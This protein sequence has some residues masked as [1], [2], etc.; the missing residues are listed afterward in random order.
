MNTLIEQFYQSFKD[1]N[2]EGMTACYADDVEFED[3][4]FGKLKGERAKNMWR[5][6]I[7]SQQGK[8]F[9]VT[10]SDVTENSAHWEAKYTFSQSGRKVHNIIKAT[11]VIENGKIIKHTDDFNLHKWAKQALG[12]KGFLLG[13]TSFFKKKLQ[14]QTNRLLDKYEANKSKN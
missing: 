4:A 5:M 3:P 14:A 2:A 1:L 7:E 9:E 6:L 12:F 11:F 8:D 10:F 13:R